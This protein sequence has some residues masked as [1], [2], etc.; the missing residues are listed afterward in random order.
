M[1][2]CKNCAHFKEGSIGSFC[3]SPDNGIDLVTGEPKVYFA[4]INRNNECGVEA[5]FYKEKQ[6]EAEPK[7]SKRVIAALFPWRL[8]G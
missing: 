8:R 3:R 5:K 7:K 6:I 2:I 1:K 4:H